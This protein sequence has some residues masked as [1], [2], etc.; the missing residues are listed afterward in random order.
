M[1]SAQ[2][3]ERSCMIARRT[4]VIVAKASSSCKSNTSFIF[5]TLCG[6]FRHCAAKAVYLDF[7]S[8]LRLD[9]AVMGSYLFN[10]MWIV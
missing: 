1:V 8:Q 10:V 4:L 2:C 7:V 9:I 3:L 5:F 6:F